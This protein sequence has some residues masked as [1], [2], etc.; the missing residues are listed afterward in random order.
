MKPVHPAAAAAEEEAA[1]TEAAAAIPTEEAE[2]AGNRD[3]NS[4]K[5]IKKAPT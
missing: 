4:K 2:D 3:R 5:D 1:A